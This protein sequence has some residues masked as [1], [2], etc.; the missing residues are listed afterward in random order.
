MLALR[1]FAKLTAYYLAVTAIVLIALKLFP[2]FA[3]SCRLAASRP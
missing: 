3:S 1:L 2:T